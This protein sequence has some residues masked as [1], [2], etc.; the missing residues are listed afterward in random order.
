MTEPIALTVT[1]AARVV[2]GYVSMI[3]DR[4]IDPD[5]AFAAL[6]GCRTNAGMM[7]DGPPWRVYRNASIPD[8]APELVQAALTRSETLLNE[9]FQPIPWTR[10]EP[11]P[12]NNKAYEDSRGYSVSVRAEVSPAGTYR[13]DVSATSPCANED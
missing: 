1:E 6:H 9:G 11:E 4:P 3:V 12:P 5:P 7:P 8:P 2:A 13:L 10:P